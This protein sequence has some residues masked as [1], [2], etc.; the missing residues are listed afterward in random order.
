M[1]QKLG[2]N[3]LSTFTK[4]LTVTKIG[5]RLWRVE[6]Q[7]TYFVGE[8]DSNEFITVPQGFT[9]D[10]A[11]SPRFAWILIPPDGCY[12]QACVLHDYMYLTKYNTR[13]RCDEIFLEAMEVLKVNWFKR[14][15][16]F[17]AVRIFAGGAWKKHRRN[18]SD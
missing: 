8:E 18:D 14:Y 13:K 1:R 6:R 11:S 17:W 10:F 7:F 3:K 9:T 2:E 16:M 4:P 15:T 5:P 12:T